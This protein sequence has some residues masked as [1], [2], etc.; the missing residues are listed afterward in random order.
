MVSKERNAQL[1]QC[2]WRSQSSATSHCHFWCST[3]WPQ[4]SASH[5][6]IVTLYRKMDTSWLTVKSSRP[7]AYL[8]W[9]NP[10]LDQKQC[11]CVTGHCSQGDKAPGD[12]LGFPKNEL[13]RSYH[14]MTKEPMD[15]GAHFSSA[16]HRQ[17]ILCFFK[18]IHSI[19]HKPIPTDIPYSFLNTPWIFLTHSHVP[20]STFP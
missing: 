12:V 17:N 15:D 19:C 14:A 1:V 4:P 18:L 20:L 3:G 11:S 9:G 2:F 5:K 6:Q 16:T 13:R 8:T 10:K 7:P